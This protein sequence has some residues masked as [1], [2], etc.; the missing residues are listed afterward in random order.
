MSLE[1]PEISRKRTLT[2]SGIPFSS[3]SYLPLRLNGARMGLFSRRP[4]RPL[5]P[6]PGRKPPSMLSH[7]SP[8]R[9]RDR[10]RD[11]RQAQ[12]PLLVRAKSANVPLLTR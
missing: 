7:T 8:R 9:L 3:R 4:L 11:G 1:K 5:C 2:A 12:A 10:G 6:I